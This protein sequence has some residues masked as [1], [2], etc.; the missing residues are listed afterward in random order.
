[1]GW[2]GSGPSQRLIILQTVADCG[3]KD[4]RQPGG[5]EGAAV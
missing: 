1:V 5:R 3:E 2:N 4:G